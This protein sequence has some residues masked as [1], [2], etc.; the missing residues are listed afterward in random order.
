MFCVIIFKNT[1]NKWGESNEIIKK[2]FIIYF[3]IFNTCIDY[4]SIVVCLYWISTKK[5]AVEIATAYFDLLNAQKIEEALSLLYFKPEYEIARDAL[6]EQNKTFPPDL[7]LEI[8]H[9]KKINPMLIEMESNIFNNLSKQDCPSNIYVMLHQKP[10]EPVLILNP[11]NV[12]DE[13][14]ENVVIPYDPDVILPNEIVG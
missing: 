7:K 6:E 8:F 1:D 3:N 9:V 12:P 13:Y 2:A 5:Q 10:G 4:Y 11:Y 14:M